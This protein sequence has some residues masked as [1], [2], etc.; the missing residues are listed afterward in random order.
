MKMKKL[1]T[2]LIG[3]AIA[4]IGTPAMAYEKSLGVAVSLAHT[5]H[6]F[7]FAALVKQ[8]FIFF[9][10]DAAL[11]PVLEQL[12]KIETKMSAYDTKSQKEFEELGK[13]TKETND[14][15]TELGLKQ[16]EL[17]DELLQIK[18]RATAAKEEPK[19][20]LAGDLFIKSDQ[21]KDFASG[22]AQKARVEVKN[23]ITNTVGN[24]FTDRRPGIVG[25]AFR[26]LTLERY[27]NTL[28]TTQNA[29]EY[30]RENVF[31]NNAAE[32]A[33]GNVKPESSI[34]TTLM[35]EPVA[36]I[37]HF[38]KISKQLAQDNP[39]LAAYINL[40]MIY[41][42]NLRVENQIISGN[43]T[44]PN[45]SGFT[46]AG[47]FTA[48]G[49]TAAALTALGLSPSN[50]FDVIGKTLGDCEAAD[51]PADVIILN[52]ADWWTLRLAKDS[53]GRYLLGDPG[54]NVVPA[55]FGVPVVSSNA[56]T[57]GKFLV[58]SLAMAATL[59]IREGVVI[60]LSD[61]D[62]DNFQRNLITVRAERRVLLAVERPAAVRYGD[63]VPA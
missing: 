28:P 61:S 62:T 40:R 6:N 10:S 36:T 30:V 7:L 21:Y 20:E 14:A 57:A 18:Q 50:R 38:L 37:A 51:Y 23:T 22:N 53:T 41:G 34:T 56:I 58:A 4:S 47:N 42:V 35:N 25:G 26:E 17:A 46:K 63:L 32:V 8:G 60:E 24:T 45:M 27:L 16:K 48:H 52:P 55:L 39:A 59:Y 9:E 2:S 54:D 11:K 49:Y 29:V 15:L 33:E 19:V 44:A 12:D 1:S 3:L 5:A 13:V 43:G 31:T